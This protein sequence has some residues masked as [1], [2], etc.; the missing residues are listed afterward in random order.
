[1]QL[2]LLEKMNLQTKTEKFSF[3]VSLAEKLKFGEKLK[4]RVSL[5]STNGKKLNFTKKPVLALSSVYQTGPTYKSFYHLD[6][7]NDQATDKW[8][9]L[10]T[11]SANVYEKNLAPGKIEKKIL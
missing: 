4:I 9:T 3:S 7:L 5:E 1:M 10:I 2:E 8:S 6:L 11:L